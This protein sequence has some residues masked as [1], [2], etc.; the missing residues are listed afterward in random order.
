MKS[1]DMYSIVQV[2]ALHENVSNVSNQQK[3]LA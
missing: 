2:Y 3:Y 1:I